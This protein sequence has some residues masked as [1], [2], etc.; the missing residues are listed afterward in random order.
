MSFEKRF[1]HVL[2]VPTPGRLRKQK[3]ASG[4]EGGEATVAK[5]ISKAGYEKLFFGLGS[6]CFVQG[7][8]TL[9]HF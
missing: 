1:H 6:S 5:N 2:P 7:V 8:A 3:E 4:G 9:H